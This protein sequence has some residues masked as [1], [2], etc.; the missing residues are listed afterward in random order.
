M[1]KFKYRSL[2]FPKQTTDQVL[3]MIN[4]KHPDWGIVQ[5]NTHVWLDYGCWELNYTTH[6]IIKETIND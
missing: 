4:D 5:I 1:N 3:E 6:V 2:N